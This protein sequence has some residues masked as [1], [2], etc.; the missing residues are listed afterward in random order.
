M[1]VIPLQF[2]GGENADALGLT[3]HEIYDVEGLTNLSPGAELI[4]RVTSDD[5]ETKE[6]KA[7]ARVD[8]PVEVEYLRNGG[9]LQTVLRQLLKE[10]A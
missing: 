6:F 8:S 9:I 7:M 4:V 3:G 5:G 2:T 10:S 1:G